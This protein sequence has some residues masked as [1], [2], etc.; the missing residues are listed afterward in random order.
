MSY[1]YMYIKE[2]QYYIGA[3]LKEDGSV[4]E[5]RATSWNELVRMMANH[6]VCIGNPGVGEIVDCP[7]G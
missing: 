5:M 7:L 4:E 2:S 3:V 6:G 1:G